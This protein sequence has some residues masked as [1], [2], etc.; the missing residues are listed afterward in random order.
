[1]GERSHLHPLVLLSSQIFLLGYFTSSLSTFLR[2]FLS[3]DLLVVNYLTVYITEN[4]SVSLTLKIWFRW[5]HKS[6]WQLLLTALQRHYST[7]F[8]LPY[9]MLRSQMLMF[10]P[11]GEIYPSFEGSFTIF[12]LFLALCSFTV[13]CMGIAILW[14]ILFGNSVFEIS[15][16]EDSY[17]DWILQNTQLLVL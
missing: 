17:L 4:V 6:D 15:T 11:L 12:S 16:Y 13:M 3:E 10:I 1:M 7:V 5:L 8:W 14:F 2:R 9:L